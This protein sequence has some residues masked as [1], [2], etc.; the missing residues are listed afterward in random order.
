MP[1]WAVPEARA[2]AHSP[3]PP[4]GARPRDARDSICTC[5][6]QC[7]AEPGGKCSTAAPNLAR[8]CPLMEGPLPPPLCVCNAPGEV[9]AS[10]PPLPYSSHRAQHT[11]SAFR[12]APWALWTS[13]LLVQE[14]KLFPN[15]FTLT[16]SLW[17]CCFPSPGLGHGS[18]P[19]LQRCGHFNTSQHPKCWILTLQVPR[20]AVPHCH[21]SLGCF[22]W[23]SLTAC[24]SCSIPT[25]SLSHTQAGTGLGP[26]LCTPGKQ[27]C[28][29]TFHPPPK[30]SRLG[31]TQRSLQKDPPKGHLPP[32]PHPLLSSGFSGEQRTVQTPAES[33][34]QS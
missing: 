26:P 2:S 25:P 33:G 13:E 19:P 31:E 17:G 5:I 16:A 28:S 14:S 6:R 8:N 24:L 23:S 3:Q 29:H 4:Y 7:K 30:L 11:G 1:P 27:R 9:S 22:G 15:L 32:E 12:A 20:S 18:A 34:A 10:P 21:T